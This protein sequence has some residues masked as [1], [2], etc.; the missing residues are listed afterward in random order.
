MDS[1]LY[2]DV[3]KK[4]GLKDR[5]HDDFK[6]ILEKICDDMQDRKSFKSVEVFLL[7]NNI[8]TTYASV[9]RI[10]GTEDDYLKVRDKGVNFI[11]FTLEQMTEN[12]KKD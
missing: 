12:Y 7:L 6:K 1:C 4:F 9:V 2:S 3:A 8:I 11:A 5:Y 10:F